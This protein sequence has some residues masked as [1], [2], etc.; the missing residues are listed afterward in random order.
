MV[1]NM[2]IGK[3]G[4]IVIE[5]DP[6]LKRELHS[7]LMMESSTLKQWF[8]SN[9]KEYLENRNQGQLDLGEGKGTSLNE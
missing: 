2:S 8:V 1:I 5:V 3:S 6:E 4:R 9:A 7:V